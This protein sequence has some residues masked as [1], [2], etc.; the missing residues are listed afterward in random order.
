MKTPQQ[1][2]A[3][4]NHHS[5][6]SFSASSV[7]DKDPRPAPL[8]STRIDKSTSVT[9]NTPSAAIV[10]RSVAPT[11]LV[12]GKPLSPSWDTPRT[13]HVDTQL[14]PNLQRPF[15]SLTVK[16]QNSPQDEE[17]EPGMLDQSIGYHPD[18]SFAMR[19]KSDV[20][21][22][23]V[24]H[25]DDTL[26]HG[27]RER[28]R[29]MSNGEEQ[30]A[31]LPDVLDTVHIP[32]YKNQEMTR[33]WVSQYGKLDLLGKKNSELDSKINKAIIEDQSKDISLKSTATEDSHV[34]LNRNISESDSSESFY[35]AS[36]ENSPEIPIPF[37]NYKVQ[38]KPE[39]QKSLDIESSELE[40]KERLVRR[41]MSEVIDDICDVVSKLGENTDN[42]NKENEIRDKNQKQKVH[43]YDRAVDSV[44][45]KPKSPL[46]KSE[47]QTPVKV[48]RYDRT[49]R[50]E[51]TPTSQRGIKTP[52]YTP[53]KQTLRTQTLQQTPKS[54]PLR[55][56]QKTPTREPLKTPTKQKPRQGVTPKR[57][58]IRTPV[59]QQT[60]STEREP[61]QTLSQQLVGK[62]DSSKCLTD[63]HIPKSAEYAV[64]TEQLLRDLTRAPQKEL[65]RTQEQEVGYK[66][67]GSCSGKNKKT[68]KSP[69]YQRANEDHVLTQYLNDGKPTCHSS[70]S[71]SSNVKQQL[72]KHPEQQQQ[73]QQQDQRESLPR[74]QNPKPY[75][76]CAKERNNEHTQQ[77]EHPRQKD[78]NESALRYQSSKAYGLHAK[79]Q[80]KQDRHEQQQC[81]S[82]EF[83]PRSHS[84]RPYSLYSK[85]LSGQ[86]IEQPQQEDESLPRSHSPKPH[87][88]HTSKQLE[89]HFQDQ[90]E[91]SLRSH[92]PESRSHTK[93]HESRHEEQ[94]D[95]HHG[96]QPKQPEQPLLKSI[97]KTPTPAPNLT[98]NILSTNNTCTSSDFARDLSFGAHSLDLSELSREISKLD[99]ADSSDETWVLR[100]IEHMEKEL[101]KEIK[102]TEKRKKEK[103]EME[104]NK[105]KPK[106][107]SKS[108]MKTDSPS[109][110][111]TRN[112]E[113]ILR[114][115][116]NGETVERTEAKVSIVRDL[117]RRLSTIYEEK[118][119]DYDSSHRSS[120]GRKSY[121]KPD[122]S[123]LRKLEEIEREWKEHQGWEDGS[124]RDSLRDSQHRESVEKKEKTALDREKQTEIDAE[125]KD[126]CRQLLE[127]ER[128]KR[129]EHDFDESAS[130]DSSFYTDD[131]S[132]LDNSGR[133]RYAI[134]TP[135]TKLEH[136]KSPRQKEYNASTLDYSLEQDKYDVRTPEVKPENAKSP[137]RKDD[138]I[139]PK[140]S[141]LQSSPNESLASVQSARSQTSVKSQGSVASS[142]KSQQSSKS[143]GSVRSVASG[144][145]SLG[146]VRSVASSMKS[147]A[148]VKSKGSTC[149][150][151]SAVSIQTVYK[152]PDE[153]ISLLEIHYPPDAELHDPD[154]TIM[155]ALES[156]V[157]TQFA[158]L[159]STHS[160]QHKCDTNTDIRDHSESDTSTEVEQCNISIQVSINLED[161][162]Q[163]ASSSV[164]EEIKV[165][166]DISRMSDTELRLALVKLG[167]TPGPII[168]ST[169]RLY[170][171]RLVK[172][173]QDPGLVKH[174]QQQQRKQC[175]WNNPLCFE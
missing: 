71:P 170:E 141:S 97:L 38:S 142:V 49:P 20:P 69:R 73:Q 111:S 92:N 3:S 68:P 13:P 19:V 29:S 109:S 103:F 172:M 157:D 36:M 144:V 169:R 158:K 42:E 15:T 174:A 151:Q 31:D 65:V 26:T 130:L 70:K 132:T 4:L 34:T 162:D 91:S 52:P 61:S 28:D 24:L 18:R 175:Y 39:Q 87:N 139:S 135:K 98:Y 41:R 17:R 83:L 80:R 10:D 101:E 54:E 48:H 64:K 133:D 149:S 112:L 106:P 46:V 160:A 43:R 40:V 56:R 155:S 9:Y 55:T 33:L 50:Q 156:D 114:R 30:K 166:I 134:R 44:P 138:N 164:T 7:D 85:K 105:D 96:K 124:I 107:V 94:D 122:E 57:E 11:K 23:N 35:T 88:L 47:S 123:E 93:R 45:L 165:P 99:T 84:P 137:K 121:G 171:E 108:H 104:P 67:D 100:Q 77:Q 95:K 62:K 146:S 143:Q 21:R 125:I 120:R 8:T 153:G 25:A 152:D 131:S 102:E 75:A 86:E 148:S 89:Q 81:Y 72:K 154:C 159:F 127:E 78:K 168:A 2:F 51:K 27:D 161:S 76:S 37:E 110:K 16:L 150:C 147:L 82:N 140:L 90:E 79:E 74:Y 116:A 1:L 136:F 32:G 113:D 59:K 66:Q 163:S 12:V 128:L 115:L 126:R 118:S 6:N 167:D 60:P 22:I 129:P 53:I 145:K 117:Y 58:Q 63:I 5:S 14:S 119:G 173:K